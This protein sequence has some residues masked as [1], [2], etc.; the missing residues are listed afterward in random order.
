M[1]N[2]LMPEQRPDKRGVV[3]TRWVKPNVHGSSQKTFAPPPSTG[4]PSG[5]T[6]QSRSLFE[7]VLDSIVNLLL[8][9]EEEDSAVD[10]EAR[11]LLRQRLTE[12]PERT[13]RN[14]SDA[15]EKAQAWADEGLDSTDFG[16]FSQRVRAQVAEL[17]REEALRENAKSAPNQVPEERADRVDDYAE[18]IRRSAEARE[19][20]EAAHAEARA[21]QQAAA[22]QESAARFVPERPAHEP[23]VHHWQDDSEPEVESG[24]SPLDEFFE[25]VERGQEKT[26]NSNIDDLMDNGRTRRHH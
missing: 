2:I 14:L 1:N 16:K 18:R 12:L 23:S 3:V 26:Y 5:K 19:A 15:W 9:P 22:A 7:K 6:E 25:D 4:A 17:L 8:G 10:Q 24:Y 11:D 13:V 20:Q 21:R